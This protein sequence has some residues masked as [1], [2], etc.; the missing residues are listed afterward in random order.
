MLLAKSCQ[1]PPLIVVAGTEAASS[2]SGG[3]GGGSIYIKTWVACNI[4]N[5]SNIIDIAG[6]LKVCMYVV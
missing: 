2:S 6:Q 3:G 1:N 4:T 5:H